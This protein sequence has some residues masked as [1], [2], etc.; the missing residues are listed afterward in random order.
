METV[1]E[2]GWTCKEHKTNI[3][4]FSSSSFVSDTLSEMLK[5][6]TRRV[7]L[8][9]WIKCKCAC[10]CEKQ[11][12]HQNHEWHWVKLTRTHRYNGSSARGIDRTIEWET[13]FGILHHSR[14][15]YNNYTFHSARSHGINWNRRLRSHMCA[16][17]YN[18]YVVRIVEQCRWKLNEI[19]AAL[20]LNV[21]VYN[22]VIHTREPL[23][24]YRSR[25][26][27]QSESV[28]RHKIFSLNGSGWTVEPRGIKVVCYYSA[29]SRLVFL[30]L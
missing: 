29:S 27:L 8:I 6:C 22:T 11:T 26:R 5:K 3:Q 30:P 14:F 7:K 17:S 9:R 28:G 4:F 12:S 13:H 25:T 10:G 15:G 20:S 24:L 1:N 21:H 23:S 19:H 2:S 18:L 16:V